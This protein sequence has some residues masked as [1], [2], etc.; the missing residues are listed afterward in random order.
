MV[1]VL[2]WPETLIEKIKFHIRGIAPAISCDEVRFGP[3]LL[4]CIGHE[5][6]TGVAIPLRLVIR[7]VWQG[8]YTQAVEKVKTE[9][10]EKLN[11]NAEVIS[12][13]TPPTAM[14]GYE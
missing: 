1:Q 12:N 7:I 10:F 2:L 6:N 8:D 11:K 4:E 5:A 13:T 3:G 9:Y 14:K